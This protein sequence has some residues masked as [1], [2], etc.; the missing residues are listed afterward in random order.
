MVFNH[1]EDGSKKDA[2]D[3][4][5]EAMF[6][7]LETA[8][9][10]ITTTPT[11]NFR[12]FYNDSDC[13]ILAPGRQFGGEYP[14]E[15]NNPDNDSLTN[16]IYRTL[17]SDFIRAGRKYRRGTEYEHFFSE[18]EEPTSSTSRLGFYRVT[19]DLL[20]KQ[21]EQQDFFKEAFGEKSEF[22]KFYEE[23]K[24]TGLDPQGNPLSKND[25]IILESLKLA[26]DVKVD[27]RLRRGYR[28]IDYFPFSIGIAMEYGEKLKKLL[29]NPNLDPKS[30]LTVTNE[31]GLVNSLL[32]IIA[33][34]FT[35]YLIG[36]SDN[37]SRRVRSDFIK[38]FNLG[39]IVEHNAIDIGVIGDHDV[40]GRAVWGK[41]LIEYLKTLGVTISQT[42]VHEFFSRELYSVIAKRIGKG[43]NPNTELAESMI[44]LSNAAIK[45]INRGNRVIGDYYNS[46][47]IGQGYQGFA[48]TR[49]GF[50]R[51][52]AIPLQVNYPTSRIR[53]SYIDGIKE[54]KDFRDKTLEIPEVKEG[55]RL[56]TGEEGRKPHIQQDDVEIIQPSNKPFP[57]DL[58]EDRFKAYVSVRRGVAKVEVNR[59][60]NLVVRDTYKLRTRKRGD[61]SA[62]ETFNA[63]GREILCLANMDEV[64]LYDTKS[65]KESSVTFQQTNSG[66]INFVS[67]ISPQ[68]RNDNSLGI[69]PHK[70]MMDTAPDLEQILLI[71]HAKYGLF[72]FSVYEIA[73]EKDIRINSEDI[74]RMVSSGG[75]CLIKDRKRSYKSDGNK[76]Y[77]AK[78]KDRNLTFEEFE[79]G[80]RTT[81][82]P[83]MP[84]IPL[85]PYGPENK[86]YLFL[87]KV[88]GIQL[89]IPELETDG[90]GEKV[91][92]I[93]VKGNK[94]YIGT[95]KGKVILCKNED[96]KSSYEVIYDNKSETHISCLQAFEYEGKNC[97]AFL[98]KK[99]TT[100][101]DG[102]AIEVIVD[103]D[104]Q[105]KETTE[106]FDDLGVNWFSIDGDYLMLNY[107]GNFAIRNLS[108]D[109][110]VVIQNKDRDFGL[111][112]HT[113]DN[114]IIN[115]NLG[116]I[117]KEISNGVT[118][119]NLT[120]VT[121]QTE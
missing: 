38:H 54:T 84:E 45:S 11:S 36:V 74:S 109:R 98:N 58:K 110:N 96:G 70:V 111:T 12:Q 31:P 1:H 115:I 117:I 75:H 19:I 41:Q 121:K 5:V 40:Y 51:G 108:Y 7:P 35:P 72:G 61:V 92:A 82:N 14:E 104:N 42:D 79:L 114:S 8:R 119:G 59:S 43:K 95:N 91:S 6:K 23:T 29:I 47:F 77:S 112:F 65:G 102:G 13:I 69:L 50:F 27:G 28:T 44:Q 21:I 64:R 33:P 80:Y 3:K 52:R 62:I 103:V 88:G 97:V 2:L 49:H 93:E 55:L 26:I 94:V 90:L 89:D 85:I 4:K 17:K 15:M 37:D 34:Q 63:L 39:G 106:L 30:I 68:H 48:V 53:N 9:K 99:V 67:V 73:V 60:G 25:K 100:G 22:Q 71:N 105:E 18:S 107:N 10:K 20:E 113:G 46:I 81:Q 32:S 78:I 83:S 57:R 86:G 87:S 16:R 118:I 101:Y 76:L 120:H 66:G 24:R 56:I 116:T